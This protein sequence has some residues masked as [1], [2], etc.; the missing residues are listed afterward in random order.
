ME[1]ICFLLLLVGNLPDTYV[2]CSVLIIKEELLQ[3]DHVL[4]KAVIGYSDF[5]KF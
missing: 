1:L 4:Y 5:W 2:K 3:R